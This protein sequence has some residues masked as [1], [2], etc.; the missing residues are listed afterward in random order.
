MV[1][2]LVLF[3]ALAASFC[4]ALMLVFTQ[5]FH[6]HLTL[7][8]HP[9]VQKLHTAPTP[10]VGGV[11]VL[12]GALAGGFVL[13]GETQ[14]LWWVI[15]ISALPAFTFG[16]LEDI[17]KRVSVKARLLATVFAGMIF[18]TLTGYRITTVD[19][20]G[21]DALLSFWVPSFLFTAFA[22]GGIANAINIIDGVNGLAAG[23]SIII[24]SGFAVLAGQVGDMPILGASLVGI[25]ALSGFFLLNFPSGR[26]FL[27]DAGAYTAGFLLAV[28]AVALPQRNPELSPLI[29]L[30]ALAYPVTETA[31]SVLRRLARKG[32]HPGAPDRLHLHSL[33][34]RGRARRFAQAINAPQLRNAMA[35]LLVMGIPLISVALMVQ[36]SHSSALIWLCIAF[37]GVLYVHL[38]RKAA[39]LGPLIRAM[40]K[41]RPQINEK[42]A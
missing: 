35:G 20:M 7:D 1:F 19:I 32:A 24:L 2:S 12:S 23:T 6:G 16:L 36:V 9:G 13:S 15:C 31:V 22:I 34:Y 17:T 5:H 25:G 27:G 11:A 42:I 8:S 29:G 38:Y 30:L 40:R 21:I 3:V 10:R 39:L 26:L 14:W 4:V 41:S 37:V 33:I 18:C 28:I